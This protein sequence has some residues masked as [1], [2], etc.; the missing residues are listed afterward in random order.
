M[1]ALIR[2]ARGKS[3]RL[4]LTGCGASGTM[5]NFGPGPGP[6]PELKT[7]IG[8]RRGGLWLKTGLYIICGGETGRLGPL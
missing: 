1:N 8:G 5:H 4:K 6:T 2:E 3:E 7:G